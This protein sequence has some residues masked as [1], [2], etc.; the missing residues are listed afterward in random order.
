MSIKKITKNSIFC[1]FFASFSGSSKWPKSG[2]KQR[3]FAF[4]TCFSRVLRGREISNFYEKF[5][6]MI[7]NCL[8]VSE[9]NE[10]KRSI[11]I[12]EHTL[13]AH[14]RGWTGVRR[15]RSGPKA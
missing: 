13:G 14:L 4:F 12:A 7:E 9:C 11:P 5:V 6:G 10:V 2:Q 3:F 8:S 1:D 15:S